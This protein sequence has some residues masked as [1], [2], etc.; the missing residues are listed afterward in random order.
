[1]PMPVVRHAAASRTTAIFFIVAP[2]PGIGRPEI[3]TDAVRA[4]LVTSSRTLAKSRPPRVAPA[5]LVVV[6]RAANGQRRDRRDSTR[7]PFAIADRTQAGNQDWC[8][9]RST[10]AAR[11]AP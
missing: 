10:A 4:A 1:M 3:N 2:W 8:E 11:P 6:H 7:R 9:A 5:A